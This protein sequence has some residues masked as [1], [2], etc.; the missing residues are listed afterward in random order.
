[1]LSDFATLVA[2]T[3]EQ[4]SKVTN[5]FTKGGLS[6]GESANRSAVGKPVGDVS[7]LVGGFATP[8]VP[9]R[10]HFSKGAR[11]V[12]GFASQKS[13]FGKPFGDFAKLQGPGQGVVYLLDPGG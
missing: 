6:V 13:T 10:D 7:K 8:I 3:S 1:M 2:N 9:S 11:P 12:G 4:F 5:R